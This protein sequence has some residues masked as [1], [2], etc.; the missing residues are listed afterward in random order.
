[1]LAFGHESGVGK[2]TICNLI[3]RLA[4]TQTRGLEVVV[5]G[6]AE[7]LK[8]LC[9]QQ[10][11]NHGH[12]QPSL[13][14]ENR[15]LR[16]I[17]LANTKMN[18]VDLWIKIGNWYR[19]VDPNYWVDK[20][21]SKYKNTDI[22]LIKDLRYPN[23]FDKIESLGGVC[24]KIKNSRVKKTGSIAD[25]ALENCNKWTG[26]ISNEGEISDLVPVAQQLLDK[27]IKPNV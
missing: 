11:K 27:H 17:Q 23:E 4:C 18:V 7:P 13:Y 9:Y 25:I 10:F 1:M 14:E 26:V 8:D 5:T 15:E 2:D 16:K 6:F 21:V 19:E 12:L 22:V 3:K 24:Y 20:L